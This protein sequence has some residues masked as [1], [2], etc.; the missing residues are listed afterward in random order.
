MSEEFR[1]GI[2][3]VD[4]LPVSP[5][6]VAD[7]I[8]DAGGFQIAEVNESTRVE[9]VARFVARREL[10]V[11]LDNCEH[12]IEAVADL[13]HRIIISGT[14]ARV[15]ATSRAALLVDDER[16]FRVPGLGRSGPDDD[17]TELLVD[18]AQA[19]DDRFDARRR[20]PSDRERDVPPTG[21]PPA[22][23]RAGRGPAR[24]PRHRR[25]RRPARSSPRPPGRRSQLGRSLAHAAVDHGMVLGAAQPGGARPPRRALG[26][27]RLVRAR[28]HRNGL[29][30]DA[31][32]APGRSAS[33]A[34]ERVPDRGG[35][36]RPQRAVPAPGDR[37]DVRRPTTRRVRRHR[38][39]PTPP[40]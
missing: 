20:R 25:P 39:G 31:V 38:R 7:A 12:V 4:L 24:A 30:I 6:R 26:V 10:L 32:R 37:P 29:L 33:T 28:R 9:A 5:T 35:P 19:L 16:V 1:D 11:V 17:A 22:R 18:R 2:V 23:H 13:V 27:P 15:L 3:F 21:R 8:V 34:R 14:G 36:Q 40:P